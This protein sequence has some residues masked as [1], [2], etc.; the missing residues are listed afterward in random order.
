MHGLTPAISGLDRELPIG[1]KA[2]QA[3]GGWYEFAVCPEVRSKGVVPR[4]SPWRGSPDALKWAVYEE[5]YV[6]VEVW[7]QKVGRGCPPGVWPPVVAC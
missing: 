6:F 7:P 3:T 1:T 5:E 2:C 4:A